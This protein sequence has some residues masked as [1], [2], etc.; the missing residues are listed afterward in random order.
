MTDSKIP[1]P[2]LS[3]YFAEHGSAGAG[4]EL[5]ATDVDGTLTRDGAL[6]AAT[7][8]AI[9]EL[10]GAGIEVVPVS[11]RPAGE[12]L[13]LCRYLPG[14]RKG[15]AENGLISVVPDQPVQFIG[16]PTNPARL[17]EVGDALNADHGANLRLAGDEFC[18]VGDVAYERDGRDVPELMRLRDAAQAAGVFFVWSSV[19]V[20]LAERIPDKGEGLLQM[21][22]RWGRAPS[23][24]AT[25]GDAP[26]D[27]GLFTP[28][29][30]GL[31]V[32]TADVVAQA[33]DFPH[34]PQMVTSGRELDGFLELARGLLDS[35][36]VQNDTH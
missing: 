19:H 4:I 23:A 24:V 32:G 25:I 22:E 9:E 13:G 18:R 29:R 36:G 12:V 21:L 14:V 30:F 26:N 17:R 35:R 5:V 28:G 31:T 15:I 6:T 33:Q 16:R 7:L 8:G 10:T 11:G 20:H 27:A 34:L 1:P 2:P 3:T